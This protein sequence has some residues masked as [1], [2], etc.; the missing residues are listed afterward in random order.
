MDGSVAQT[1]VAL[2]MARVGAGQTYIGTF[3]AIPE[4]HVGSTPPGPSIVVPLGAGRLTAVQ[5]T[6][7]QLGVHPGA[8][9]KA[10]AST[11]G[12]LLADAPSAYPGELRLRFMTRDGSALTATSGLPD[13]PGPQ[14]TNIGEKEEDYSEKVI[15]EIQAVNPRNPSQV[16]NTSAPVGIVEFANKSYTDDIKFFYDGLHGTDLLD[17]SGKI[18]GAATGSFAAMANG[19]VQVELRAVIDA[20][21]DRQ[22]LQPVRV[23]PYVATLQPVPSNPSDPFMPRVGP[24][25]NVSHWVDE[26]NYERRRSDKLKSWGTPDQEND[27]RDW[28]ERK[29]GDFYADYPTSPD[30][31]LEEA[32]HLVHFFNENP[33]QVVAAQVEGNKTDE[34]LFRTITWSPVAPG[35]RRFVPHT[36]T[37]LGYRVDARTLARDYFVHVGIH[38]ARHCWQFWQSMPIDKSGRGLSDPDNDFLIL[39]QPESAKELYDAHYRPATAVPPGPP[40][41]HSNPDF[42]FNPPQAQ[43]TPV[44][45]K[46]AIERDAIRFAT[47]RIDALS[48]SCVIDQPLDLLS[49]EHELNPTGLESARLKVRVT[50]GGGSPLPAMPVRWEIVSG[51]VSYACPLAPCQGAGITYSGADDTGVAE[52]VLQR[53]GEQ[54]TP[55]EVHATVGPP[56]DPADCQGTLLGNILI[57]EGVFTP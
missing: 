14:M 35:L 8:R 38:E 18:G 5:A 57:I 42:H 15:L 46:S 13:D 19:R 31:E 4:G 37:E 25:V 48:R 30:Q 43:Q 21:L 9:S 12:A 34:D 28:V 11:N 3:A 10:T 27:I 7:E 26:R 2:P 20:R 16:Q 41:P 56:L 32:L 51:D 44:Q 54:A 52:L 23:F 6:S 29:A 17:D 49:T 1:G 50:Y 45:L 24:S 40:D 36:A 33:A 53:A 22:T 47:D 55:Y 39:D